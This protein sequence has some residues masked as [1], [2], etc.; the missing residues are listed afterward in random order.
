MI[1]S[2][3]AVSAVDLVEHFF[4]IEGILQ[5]EAQVVTSSRSTAWLIA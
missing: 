5:G 2:D 3:R 4:P 1:V